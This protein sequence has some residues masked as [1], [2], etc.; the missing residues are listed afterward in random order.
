MLKALVCL[1]SC[2]AVAQKL[3]AVPLLLKPKEET[4]RIT[5]AA[6]GLEVLRNAPKVFGIIAAVGPTRTGKST[7]LGRAF[8]RGKHE[9]AFEIGGGVTSF[10]TGAHITNKP[11][12]LDMPNGRTLPVYLIDTE[13]F[14][15]IGGRTSKT[16]EANLFGLMSLMSSAV[17]FNTVFPVDASTVS[18]LNRFASHAVSVLKELNLHQTVVSR[19]P[20]TLLWTVQ[21]FNQFNLA[22]SKL[23]VEQL[24]EMLSATSTDG[25]N[26]AA[27]KLL[28]VG[29]GSG[30]RRGL[31][32]SL[33]VAQHLHPVRRPHADDEVV[34]NIAKHDSSELRQD[35]LSDA[36]KLKDLASRVVVPAHVCRRNET[37]AHARDCNMRPLDG[38]SFV[39]MLQRWVELG[40]ITVEEGGN[41]A[42]NETQLME[43]YSAQ[44][45]VWMR[46]RCGELRSLLEKMARK[47]NG[48]GCPVVGCPRITSKL[49]EKLQLLNKAAISHMVDRKEF[50]VMPGK[51]AT[52]TERLSGEQTQACLDGLEELGRQR[53]L[54]LTGLLTLTP[55]AGF[56]EAVQKTAAVEK[57]SEEKAEPTPAPTPTAAQPTATTAE[58]AATSGG[59]T[60]AADAQL[61]QAA[62]D[63][64]VDE[65]ASALK[66]KA[67]A[68]ASG[69]KGKAK[70]KKKLAL[71]AKRA[72]AQALAAHVQRTNPYSKAGDATA[73]PPAAEP[74]TPAKR[75]KKGKKK[76]RAS[77]E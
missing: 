59:T 52:L 57:K 25:F 66:E 47:L 56:A 70:G 2:A 64:A 55:A 74:P 35:Y 38:A 14:S 40:H 21:N 54:N 8:L 24:H 62:V 6:E 3:E 11:V 37:A 41:K 67:R 12:L 23:T 76:K 63:A 60:P 36:G 28:G 77:S 44:F 31:L 20:P 65:A 50:W 49:N 16:Y 17:I 10:T 42:L 1:F 33:F 58:S 39:E 48:N 29:R 5:L 61:L 68:A 32:S 26:P 69:M 13:G 4:G 18:M 19:R 71:I 72:V 9:N 15:G 30:V 73:T 27:A 51:I 22:N 45:D 53:G 75:K 46:W 34:A 7:I 43:S